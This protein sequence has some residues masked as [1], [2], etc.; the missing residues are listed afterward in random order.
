MW[1]DKIRF[2]PVG[3]GDLSWAVHF[4][5]PALGCPFSDPCNKFY[6]LACIEWVPPTTLSGGKAALGTTWKGKKPSHRV[7]FR[8]P[9]RKLNPPH[10]RC[11]NMTYKWGLAPSCPSP[12]QHV[13]PGMAINLPGMIAILCY[14]VSALNGQM[15]GEACEGPFV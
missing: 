5:I 3:I 2:A 12:S 6:I 14:Q 11:P 15:H 7:S 13:Q 10:R 4:L 9:S 8:R 1:M